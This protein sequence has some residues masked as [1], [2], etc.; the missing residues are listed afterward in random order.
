MKNQPGRRSSQIA[1][2]IQ[3]GEAGGSGLMH[4]FKRMPEDPDSENQ[5]GWWVRIRAEAV[6]DAKMQDMNKDNIRMTH[7]VKLV[8]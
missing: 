3:D 1:G 8:N 2:K 6:E 4:R 5:R 7:Y